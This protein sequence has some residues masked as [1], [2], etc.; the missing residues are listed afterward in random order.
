LINAILS[1]RSS[2]VKFEEYVDTYIQNSIVNDD[3]D[4]IAIKTFPITRYNVLETLGTNEEK[5]EDF[6]DL[7]GN[8]R[9]PEFND[10]F[11]Y[12]NE[13]LKNTEVEEVFEEDEEIIQINSI[14][15]NVRAITFTAEIEKETNKI[16]GLELKAA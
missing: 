14:E 2:F 1:R 6:I 11:S 3:E 8:K 9:F 13:I 10:I 16:L 12:V 4:L 15:N 5:K 7:I